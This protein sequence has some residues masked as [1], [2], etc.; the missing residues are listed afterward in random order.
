MKLKSKLYLLAVLLVCVLFSIG[1]VQAAEKPL[2]IGISQIVEHPALNAVRDGIIDELQAAGYARGEDVIF[3]LKSAQGDFSNAIS[4]SQTFQSEKADIVVAIA[5][6]T[7]Q[8]A[9]QVIKDKPVVVSAVTNL[10]GAGLVESFD[11]YENPANNGNITGASDQIPVKEEF[12]LIQEL[13]PSVEKVGIIYNS[14]EANSVFLTKLARQACQDLDIKLVEATVTNSA[15]VNAA[16]QSLKGRVDAIWISTDNTVV[17]A[18]PIV[19][20][21]AKE[22]QVPLVVGDP[23]SVTEGSLI[24]FGFDYYVHGRNTGKIVVQIIEGKQPNEIPIYVAKAE[25]LKLALNLDVA[26]DINFSFPEKVI[27]QADQVVFGGKVWIKQ[28]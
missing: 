19:A 27:D 6:P 10:V 18:L 8:A 9:A 15:E 3:M 20:E 1:A 12:E 22:E 4:I 23:T 11:A 2:K 14:G 17:S 25:D 5:T 28:K 26:K 21:V 16:A 24:G 13:V 7:S